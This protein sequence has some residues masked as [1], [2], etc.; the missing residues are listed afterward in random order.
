MTTANSGVTEEPHD[1]LTRLCAQMTEVLN[2]PDNADVQAGV[3]LSA[4]DTAGLVFHGFT[5]S[6][7]GV[8]AVFLHLQAVFEANGKRMD[9][10]SLEDEGVTRVDG[11]DG[12]DGE[13]LGRAP[14]R[15]D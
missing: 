6:I 1:R 13:D 14:Q 12:R 5:D 10:M 9:F 15:E 2:T 7:E 11:P 8:A 4:G 3:F